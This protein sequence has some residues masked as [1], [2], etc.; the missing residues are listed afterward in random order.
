MC[1]SVYY[2]SQYRKEA[3]IKKNTDYIQKNTNR[4]KAIET[5]NNYNK[6]IA[7]KLNKECT[8]AISNSIVYNQQ[9][10]ETLP[11]KQGIFYFNNL[12]RLL[13]EYIS[14]N[15]LSE[16]K[17]KTTLLDNYYLSLDN[18]LDS[19][20]NK[21]FG[22]IMDTINSIMKMTP[23]TIQELKYSNQQ[24]IK[25]QIKKLNTSIKDEFVT[26]IQTELRRIMSF[27]E[28]RNAIV[29]TETPIPGIITN[30]IHERLYV[31]FYKDLLENK[32]FTD[33]CKLRDDI[34]KLESELESAY[35]GS[36]DT[37]TSKENV[38]TGLTEK[39]TNKKREFAKI[40]QRYTLYLICL[41]S[42]SNTIE[43]KKLMTE[44]LKKMSIST[45]QPANENAVD[46]IMSA[47]SRL[48]GKLS[49]TP[50]LLSDDEN[51]TTIDQNDRIAERE[52]VSKYSS[53][54]VDYEKDLAKMNGDT[55]IDPVSIF[56]NVERS[57]I[58]FLEG[59]RGGNSTGGDV[60]KPRFDNNKTVRGTFL[61]NDDMNLSGSKSNYAKVGNSTS[62]L[63]SD[64]ST[65][66]TNSVVEGFE[67]GTG[68]TTATASGTTGTVN[69]DLLGNVGQQFYS[70]SQNIMDN[71]MIKG[72]V[73]AIMK[74]LRLDNIQSSEQLGVLL[75][76]VSA[77]L[78]FIDLS[79]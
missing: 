37:I 7:E 43:T 45:I 29:I 24:K 15:I 62:T 36:Y 4:S 63:V 17:T 49:S 32:I 38:V 59:V 2:L 46:N 50:K 16:I 23:E 61:A 76:V 44:E 51:K 12:E 22:L 74:V 33:F 18:N 40:H 26:E 66:K 39:I 54:N 41:E 34:K 70:I 52:I 64:G 27:D 19:F 35:R 3:L 9:Q 78:F 56:S 20:V 75:I 10:I 21:H 25:E 28:T 14:K 13:E 79:S 57:A 30:E 53:A 69:Q 77:L 71:D 6:Q 72:V 48:Y 11:N 58:S 55:R 31:K 8:S 73:G 68:E 47:K 5:F 65:S 42:F 67:D 60:F 1:I